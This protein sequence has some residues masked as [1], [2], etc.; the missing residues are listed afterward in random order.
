MTEKPA[1]KKKHINDFDIIFLL[2][3][4][5][6]AFSFNINSVSASTLPDAY[7]IQG[8]DLHQQRTEFLCG[9][10]AIDMVFDFWG[11]NIN[12]KAIADVA[13]TSPDGTYTW[14]MVRT[15]HFSSLS[16]AEGSQFSDHVPTKG[17]KKR[18]RG[19]A[20]FNYSSDKIWWKE[21]KALIASDIP[22]ILLMKWSPDDYEGHYRVIVGYDEKKNV[23]YFM[24]PWGRELKKIANPDGTVTWNKSDFKKAWNYSEY[25]TPHPYWGAIML[26]WSVNLYADDNRN[27]GSIINI[28]ARITYPCP[29]PF[30]CN[31]FPASNTI[32]SIK[33]PSG[34]HIEKGKSKKKIGDLKAG[35]S[36]NVTWK[37]HLNSNGTGSWIKVST[38][39]IVS[40]SVPAFK[41]SG[42]LYHAYNY[43]DNIGGK[44]RL[45]I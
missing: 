19:Y 37:V 30:N 35:E 13:R 16:A 32:A 33:L 26:P 15:G 23:V 40:G 7:L 42:G 43:K 21:L 44:A 38:G 20:A 14:D 2:I 39:G 1:N 6:L 41:S 34:L 24:D 45:K 4:I 27:S 11:A 18:S 5:Y 31:D 9:P 36:V 29:E 3:S 25:G 10:G 17:F 22:V 12:Q 8:I 28:T